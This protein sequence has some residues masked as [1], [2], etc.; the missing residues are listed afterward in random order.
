MENHCRQYDE[1]GGFVSIFSRVTQKNTVWVGA[2]GRQLGMLESHFQ[3]SS[4][5][6]IQAKSWIKS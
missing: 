3:F 6:R 2:V 4:E 1:G 5:G